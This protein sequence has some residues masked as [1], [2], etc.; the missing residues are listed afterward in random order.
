[1]ALSKLDHQV[2]VPQDWDAGLREKIFACIS[3]PNSGVIQFPARDN[4]HRRLRRASLST[5]HYDLIPRPQPLTHKNH[6][7]LVT[8]PKKRSLRMSPIFTYASTVAASLV[9]GAGLG[10]VAL[11]PGVQSQVGALTTAA[12]GLLVGESAPAPAV[13][14][15]LPVDSFTAPQMDTPPIASA[16]QGAARTNV[17]TSGMSEK[18][19]APYLPAQSSEGTTV[20]IQ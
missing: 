1:M 9:I 14:T 10:F 6:F 18:E 3:D 11:Q 12:T 8:P 19:T 17:V 16:P 20:E 15:S 5:T 13:A 2:D 7:R 4:P